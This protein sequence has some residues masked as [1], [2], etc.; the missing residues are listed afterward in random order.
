[1]RELVAQVQELSENAKTTVLLQGETGTGKEFIARV[2]HH[3]GPRG[4]APFVGVNC[5]AIPQE[6]YSKA[7]CSG[8][9]AG[10]LPAPPSEN[11]GSANR[12]KAARCSWMKSGT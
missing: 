12:L 2:L 9:N 4:H 8:M 3:N 10:P 6:L 5:T 11:P 1:M 7:N